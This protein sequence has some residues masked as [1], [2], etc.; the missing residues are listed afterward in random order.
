MSYSPGTI[1]KARGREWVVLPAGDDTKIVTLKPLGGSEAETAGILAGLESIESASF[2][3]PDPSRLG[4]WTSARLLREAARLSTRNAAGAIR[5]WSRI[6]AEPRPYQLV[7]LLMALRMD[8]VR[9]LIADDVGIGKTIEALLIA[10]ELWDRGEITRMAVLAPPALVDQWVREMEGKFHLEA[11]PVLAGTAARLERGLPAGRSLFEEYPV[12]VVSLDFIKAEKRRAEFLRTCPEFVI[13]DE[14]HSC[15]PGMGVK[16]QRFALLEELSADRERHILLVTATPH[17]GKDE[18]FGSLV[19]LLAPEIAR[20]VAAG[21]DIRDLLASRMVQRR[22]PDIKKY[23]ETTTSF[24]R[25]DEKETKYLFSD[26]YR[27]FFQHVIDHI[28]GS[29][30]EAEKGTRMHRVRWWSAL[31][32]LRAVSSSPRAAAA[33]LR[34]RS[35]PADAESAAEADELGKRLVLDQDAVDGAE[36]MDAVPGAADD[37]GGTERTPL[38]RKLRELAREADAIPAGDDAKLQLLIK[39]IKSLLAENYAPIVFCRF[40]DTAEYV[41]EELRLSLEKDRDWKGKTRVACAT[42]V[43][44]PED[45]EGRIAELSAEAIGEKRPV[46][47]AT[48]CL[49]EGVNLQDRFTAVVHYDLAWNPTRHEQREGRVDRFGQRAATVRALTIYGAN[50]PV[51]GIVLNVLI[52]KH[53]VIKSATGVAIPVP[54]DSSDVLAA[55]MEGLDF[56]SSMKKYDEGQAEFDFGQDLLIKR[57]HLHDTWEDSARRDTETRT[58]FAQRSIDPKEVAR[59]L[60]ELRASSGDRSALRW[61]MEFSL[62]RLGAVVTPAPDSLRVNPQGLPAW[63]C[64]QAGLRKD[65]L[66]GFDDEA[67]KTAAMLTRSHP[68]VSALAGHILESALDDEGGNGESPASRAGVT[69]TS[70]VTTRTVLLLVR[71]RYDIE[72]G[73]GASKRVDLAEDVGAVAFRPEA[74][75]GTEMIAGPEAEALFAAEPSGSV[76]PDLAREAIAKEIERLGERRA[77]IAA[78]GKRRAAAYAASFARLREAASLKGGAAKVEPRGEPDILGLYIYLPG[79]AK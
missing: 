58:R 57:K 74:G 26:A 46:L 75:G 43:L 59:E 30:Q 61:F 22:R 35:A 67:P 50:N 71:F 45:R 4:D 23:L 10:R 11:V 6:D 62:K 12:T 73:R 14:A 54:M 65:T 77:G 33:T 9:L 52:R 8:T 40:I 1:V 51:D 63:L 39:E 68:A 19:G 48:D 37:E 53:K 76:A 5:S 15:A 32:L 69:K 55:I 60:A 7:P 17:S 18:A 24:P 2:A 72:L 49:S 56:R 29:M 27:K 16:H 36:G 78:E 42:G 66:F 25:R 70:A 13:V 38:Q 41:A 31:A 21:S 34:T 47:V 20:A 79:G 44:S 64:D 28:Q 3:P